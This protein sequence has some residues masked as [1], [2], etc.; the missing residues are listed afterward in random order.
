MKN[1]LFGTFVFLFSCAFPQEKESFLEAFKTYSNMNLSA[2]STTDS[3]YRIGKRHCRNLSAEKLV[4]IDSV[5]SLEIDNA[6]NTEEEFYWRMFYSKILGWNRVNGKQ[7]IMLD[8]SLE[9]AKDIGETKKIVMAQTYLASFYFESRM[10]DKAKDIIWKN[11]VLVLS[12]NDGKLIKETTSSAGWLLT[13]IGFEEKD[14]AI[15]DSAVKYNYIALKQLD[16]VRGNKKERYYITALSMARAGRRLESIKLSQELI[17]IATD[18]LK[19]KQ[20]IYPLILEQFF[21]LKMKDSAYH[22]I[23]LMIENTLIYQE[24]KNYVVSLSDGRKI[25]IGKL[26]YI[27]KAYNIFNEPEKTCFLVD[28]FLAQK[29]EK[30]EKW[31]DVIYQYGGEAYVK[32]GQYKKAYECL[33]KLKMSEDATNIRQNQRMEEIYDQYVQSSIFLEQKRAEETQ[34]QQALLLAQEEENK[35]LQLKLFLI[36]FGA[37]AVFSILLFTRFKKT[38]AQ[39][40]IIEYQ[41]MEVEESHKEIQDS[42][43]YAKRIQMAILP[44]DEEIKSALK[45]SF[46][47]Y[48]PKD[49]VAG[50]FYW[51]ETISAELRVA[52]AE[53]ARDANDGVSKNKLSTLQSSPGITL[54]AAADCTGHGV[55]GAMV[56]VICNSA[57]NRSAREFGLR[58]P[59]EILDK[60]RELV[61]EEFEKSTEMV[62]DGMD[63][64]LVSLSQ[65]TNE[66]PHSQNAFSLSYA[67]AHNP[68][69]IIRNGTD[70]IEEIKA[71]SQPIGKFDKATPFKTHEIELFKGD[72]I[73]LFSD[74]FA[75]Q[76]GGEK[77]KKMKKANFKKL[78]I[79]TQ[80]ENMEEQSQLLDQ[81]FEKWR[82]SLEQLDDVCVIGIK[83]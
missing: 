16:S 20:K 21:I 22:Y 10:Y 29:N 13:N 40:K 42:I 71:D 65:K 60:T 58:K 2:Q 50:D 39:K 34:K 61:M 31:F 12:T 4:E 74:G 35:S 62:K 68:L 57:L 54:L 28:Q 5:L 69:W 27:L 52:S 30:Q 26:L 49:I 19:V 8:R 9:I 25:N 38:K 17:S 63:I 46:I 70:E 23:D 36:I 47:L 83:V 72:R 81:A 76:F 78:V 11:M 80:S 67:G 64:A 3:L 66:D 48:K 6:R 15:Q 14:N 37:L 44:P 32:T 53:K 1:L 56:S 51:M 79:A 77:G 41:K 33:N 45:N 55:P 43:T 82:G 73:Y 59:G 24:Q 7:L 18:T 75:D